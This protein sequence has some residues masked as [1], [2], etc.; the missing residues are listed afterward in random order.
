MVEIRA[1]N[2]AQ[3]ALCLASPVAFGY[4]EGLPVR[5][6]LTLEIR[7]DLGSIDDGILPSKEYNAPMIQ[8]ILSPQDIFSPEER[9]RQCMSDPHIL[10]PEIPQKPLIGESWLA[11]CLPGLLAPAQWLWKKAE[12][13]KLY[14]TSGWFS[15][16]ETGSTRMTAA[17]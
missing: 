17:I 14:A 2:H 16:I 5:L 3:W 8:N 6:C 9:P 13:T 7:K 15:R 11:N 1:P 12:G 4:R 10:R